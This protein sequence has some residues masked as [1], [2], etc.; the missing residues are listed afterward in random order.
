MDGNVKKNKRSY[1]KVLSIM[2]NFVAI[3]RKF[4]GQRWGYP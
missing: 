3:G 2:G 1:D 4:N